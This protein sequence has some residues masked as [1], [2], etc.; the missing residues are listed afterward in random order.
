LLCG[1]VTL[2]FGM[3]FFGVTSRA[4]ADDTTSYYNFNGT[5]STDW[6]N[7]A[8]WT[9]VVDGTTGTLPIAGSTADVAG[10]LTAQI[11]TAANPA[12]TI[13]IEQLYVG[14]DSDSHGPATFPNPTPPP[15]TIQFPA[16]ATGNG[17]VIQNAGTLNVGGANGWI[18]LG[19]VLGTTGTYNMSGTAAVALTNDWFSVG[20]HG[21]GTL[22]M[23]DSAAITTTN[24]TV[25]R[26]TDGSGSVTMAKTSSITA[27][28]EID[29]GTQGTGT[30]TIGDSAT[31][32]TGNRLYVANS[33]GS[34][35]TLNVSG[36]A[37]I[38]TGNDFR[39]GDN[40][41]STGTVNQTGGTV[42]EMPAGNWTIVGADNGKG[43]Y[44]QSGGTFESNGWLVVGQ[45]GGGLANGTYNLSGTGHLIVDNQFR[46]G[47]DGVGNFTQGPGTTV[48]QTGDSSSGDHWTYIGNNTGDT[49]TYTLN[50]GT[51]NLNRVMLGTAGI[52]V[53]VQNNGTLNL[54]RDISVGDSGGSGSYTINGGTLNTVI[55]SATGAS[56]GGGIQLGWNV[57][58]VIT[59]NG[60]V[61]NTGTATFNGGLQFGGNN[62]SPTFDSMGNV[63][64]HQTGGSGGFYNLNGGVLN[65]FQIYKGDTNSNAVFNFNGGTLQPTADNPTYMQGIVAANVQA[66]G[67]IIDLQGHNITIA[68]NITHDPGI[69]AT[70]ADGGLRVQDSVGGGSL[71]L[72]GTNTF[73]GLTNVKSGIL[74]VNSANAL[75]GSTLNRD[76]ANT[77]TLNFATGIGAFTLGG[78]Q[79]SVNLSLQD[80]GPTNFALTVGGNGFSTTYTG[81]LSNGS[82]LTKAGAGRLTLTAAQTYGGTTQINGGDLNL[83][84]LTTSLPAGSAVTVGGASASGSPT[85]SGIGTV[86]S[87]TINGSVGGVAGHVAP[88]NNAAGSNF[89]G[90]G[91][92]NVGPLTLNSGSVLDLDFGAPPT[93]DLIASSGALS[94]PSSGSVSLN[95]NDTGGFGVGTYKII[96][97]TSTTNFTAT[98]FSVNDGIIGFQEA[99]TNPGGTEVD[100]I[101][102]PS[103][104]WKQ[105]AVSNAWQDAGNWDNGV[106]GSTS[107]PSSDIATFGH[108]SNFL[109]PTPD[110]NRDVAGIT[111]DGAGIGAYVIGATGG[112]ALLLTSGGT[113]QA[114]SSVGSTETVNAPLVLAGADAT[115]RFLSNIADSSKALIFGGGITGQAGT[116]VGTTLTLDGSSTGA[117]AINGVIANGAATSLS[118]V[119]N[120]TG[121]W[122]LAGNNTFTGGVAIN[123]GTLVVGN[124]NALGTGTLTSNG[125]TLQ[126]STGGPFTVGNSV[127]NSGGLTV[128][129]ANDF[130]L[131]GAISGAGSLTKSGTNTVTLTNANSF[132]GGVT[133]NSG[134]LT[135]G[136]NGA[137]GAGT[138]TA[139]GGNLST[140]AGGPYTLS[141]AINLTSNLGVSGA[142]D[143]T[144]NGLISG[145]GGLNKTGANTLTLTNTN[146]FSGGVTINSGTVNAGPTAPSTVYSALGT[147]TVTLTGT[148]PTLNLKGYA[149]SGPGL[150]GQFY[151]AGAANVGNQDPAYNLLST[152]NNQLNALTPTVTAATTVGGKADLNFSNGGTLN[153]DPNT[154][155][156][157]GG[158]AREYMFNKQ[159]GP[160]GSTAAY[161]FPN[162]I[163]FEPAGA[164]PGGTV[165][166]DNFQVRFSGFIHIT[167]ADTY[168]F[169][170]TSDDGSVLFIDGGDGITPNDDNPLVN[171]NAYQG[172]TLKVGGV[173]LSAGM[174]AITVG[175]Y[176]GGGGLGL[177][178]TYADIDGMGDTGGKMVA[179]PNSVLS[180]NTALSSQQYVNNVVVSADSTINVTGSLDASMGALSIGANTLN[181][182]S[183]DTTTTAYSLTF[184][185]ATTLTGNATINVANSS[186]G[187][188]GTA[189]VNNVSGAF[190]LTKGGAGTLS[191]G[192]TGTYTGGT[193]ISGGTVVANG[194][195]TLGTGAVTFNNATTLRAVAAGNSGFVPLVP[196][197]DNTA[198]TWTVNG[199]AAGFVNSGFTNAG[200]ASSLMLTDGNGGEAS[201][202]WF[203]TPQ[204]VNN[205]L[206]IKFT[207]QMH[208]GTSTGDPAD[209]TTFAFQN[210]A[211]GTAALGGG[212]GSMGYAGITNSAAYEINIYGGHQRG[213]AVGI[214]GAINYA[215]VAP[216]KFEGD[217]TTG[218]VV[219]VTLVYDAGAGTI[220]Q[221]LNDTT[222]NTMFTSVF[223]L[224]GTLASIVGGNTALI[225]FTGATGGSNST[226]VVSNFEF[227]TA[228]TSTYV[229]N[230]VVNG[231]STATID[232]A[233]NATVGGIG[234]GTLT[235]NSGVGTTLNLT[236]TTAPPNSNYELDFTSGTFN[237]SAAVNIA[238]NGTGSGTLRVGGPST[239]ANGVALTLSGGHVKFTNSGAAAT[240]GTGVSVTVNSSASLEL[241]GTTSNLSNSSAAA[242]RVHVTNNSTQAGGGG[243]KVTGTNQ[244]TGA[245]DGT[246]DTVVS[247]GASLTANHIIQNALVIGGTSTS[248]G[249]VT[250]AS[251]DASGNPVASGLAIAGSLGGS[252]SVTVGSSS[253]PVVT[254]P[255][256]S[257][258]SGSSLGSTGLVGGTA[259]VPEPSSVVLV[260]LG[261]LAC[262]V[263]IVRRKS[264]QA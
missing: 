54:Q 159:A 50:G 161:G 151:N 125:G 122:T 20:E 185:G 121:S 24:L 183:T 257:H 262:L 39:I 71:T 6:M 92:L 232:L 59:Q 60:G 100:M 102:T 89:G 107:G 48:D 108:P 187:G 90:I 260:V 38:N 29:I 70:T 198:L 65:T 193:V 153:S 22:T 144:L 231:G 250:I 13:N 105:V 201:S 32:S 80:T 174:H 64:G 87:V 240:V 75:G 171:N 236:A 58:G 109:N 191:I 206:R 133:L 180:Y 199:T 190:S 88:G 251:S 45:G 215:S 78:I 44:N 136:N 119:K 176:E 57:P 99:F 36:N 258:S 220:T 84:A 27:S 140:N 37:V 85:I 124:N 128:S 137:L 263:T 182:T 222:A 212:G 150:L 5:A 26:W 221:M 66:G 264:R 112:N 226:Q 46:I 155:G 179:I 18:K 33:P 131:S 52:G 67:A 208:T 35:G 175:Y 43:I 158:G 197:L 154:G 55:A 141:N 91:T 225:G 170:T 237:G 156:F 61:V 104:T 149:S 19:Q 223:P 233:T 118:I 192:G 138:L 130:T 164:A 120:G 41:G 211:T 261:A 31:L 181:V 255:G 167:K 157:T 132:G 69:P 169:T 241:A 96:T 252:S 218:D 73:N 74:N 8:N 245:I 15:P 40:L 207:Y 93:S 200:N 14:Q 152:M 77:G 68:Q 249:T 10:G 210:A 142:S 126:A 219:Q 165:G 189:R 113:V 188:A 72:T 94:L 230:V 162:P 178:V 177:G 25:G 97:S 101:V 42:T 143:L 163:P 34:T 81:V 209:G 95:L 3:L 247:A 148:N 202:A 235:V 110:P 76:P 239:F 259:A 238:A 256:G 147:G 9:S 254:A 86:G 253:A 173:A 21:T 7:G 53:F 30:L 115:Y 49:G 17:T 244:Q 184:S 98:R 116:A 28:N 63:S 228:T 1:L 234:M 145:S 135:V 224:G 246:G 248:H 229:N 213:A 217:L 242:D 106:P 204:P 139:A 127:T 117:N 111:F 82:G 166:L 83:S 62:A 227:D 195:A 79:G 186:G 243:L 203:N 56:A 114:T 123:S 146:T 194:P 172:M 47:Q 2:S 16:I 129:G 160:T 11:G 23:T 214:N 12:P 51:A 216:V 205:G 196:N 168:N 103:P 4:L 134:T